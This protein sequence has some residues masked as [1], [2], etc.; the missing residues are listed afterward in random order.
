MSK[1]VSPLNFKAWIEENRHLLKPPVGNKVVWKDADFIV[2][3]VGGPNSRKDYHYNETPE[4]FYQVE[5]DII[6]KIIDK[7]TPKDV[8]IKEG[9]IYLLPAKVPH[10]PQRGANTVGLVIEYKRP[11]GMKDALVWFCENCVTK[12]YE[13]DFTLEN[14]ETDMP[15]IFDNYYSDQHK[16][17]CPNCSE[18]MQ[19]PK[20]V[21]IE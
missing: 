8:H 11:E 15:K 19:P 12:L 17:T 14:I 13:E 5:G 4:F 7:G 16:R 1:L 20:K 10:S 2:M 6:L 9:D 18:V 3:V 21:E